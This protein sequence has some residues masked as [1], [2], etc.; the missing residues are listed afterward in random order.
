ITP[1]IELSH[2]RR[3]LRAHDLQQRLD[4]LQHAGDPAKREARRT[5]A[6]DLTI[7][8]CRKPADDVD[9][10][11]RGRGVIECAVQFYETLARVHRRRRSG[12]SMT[13]NTSAINPATP[14]QKE[15]A[16]QA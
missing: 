8:R 3:G 1:R 10:V 4:R 13:N 15:T 14:S 11:R 2:E 12:P 5:E 6:H 7:G 16:P 9:R